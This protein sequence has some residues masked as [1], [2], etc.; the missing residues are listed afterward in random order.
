MAFV[1]NAAPCPA[2]EVYSRVR[3]SWRHAS[4]TAADQWQL[5]L[6][7][8]S[9]SRASAFSAYVAALDAEEAAADDMA[10]LRFCAAA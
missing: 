3:D 7:A 2:D 4:Q 1:R 6:K 9:A 5:Y 10:R 8:G